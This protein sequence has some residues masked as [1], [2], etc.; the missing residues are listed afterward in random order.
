[1]PLPGF[2]FWQ[3]Y[4]TIFE[5]YMH[6]KFSSSIPTFTKVCRIQEIMS[7]GVL[8]LW[9]FRASIIWLSQEQTG[10]I[11]ELTFSF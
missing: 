7:N 1:M 11:E 2:V 4:M 8:Q 3:K 10:R 5:K 6:T 9:Q